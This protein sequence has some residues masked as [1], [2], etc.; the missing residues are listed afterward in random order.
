MAA[1]ACTSVTRGSLKLVAVELA[2]GA[3]AH[4]FECAAHEDLFGEDQQQDAELSLDYE[5]Q[6]ILGFSLLA[7]AGALRGSAEVWGAAE[8]AR[9][10]PPHTRAPRTRA[11]FS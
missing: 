10:H 2:T 11:H 7:Q 5:D 4:L 6:I 9:R 3:V 1:S 8:Q